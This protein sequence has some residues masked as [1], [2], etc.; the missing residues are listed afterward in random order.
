MKI[1]IPNGE[2]YSVE[3][4]QECRKESEEASISITFAIA[5]PAWVYVGAP[6]EALIEALRDTASE[7]LAAGR[8]KPRRRQCQDHR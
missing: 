1:A 7:V 6:H 4:A 5:A 2:S 8:K 3:A